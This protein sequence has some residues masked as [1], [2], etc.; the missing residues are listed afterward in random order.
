MI[1]N[2]PAS[3]KEDLEMFVDGYIEAML[4]AETATNSYGEDIDN[5]SEYDLSFTAKEEVHKTCELFLGLNS[6][7]VSLAIA[8]SD[9]YDYTMAGRDFWLTRQGHGAGFWDRDLGLIGD[10]LSDAARSF[11][12]CHVF[13][14]EK[15]EI[16][17]E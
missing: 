14:D 16:G 8:S 5:L 12:E 6:E 17:V 13:I 2:I 10:D 4:F 9:N 11:G 7:K 1:N 3:D 15:D